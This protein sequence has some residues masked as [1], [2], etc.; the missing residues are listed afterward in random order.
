MMGVRQFSEDATPFFIQK[1][2]S[3]FP[4]VRFVE[5]KNSVTNAW[6]IAGRLAFRVEIKGFA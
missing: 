1:T 6:A 2:N 3:P 4:A 5:G